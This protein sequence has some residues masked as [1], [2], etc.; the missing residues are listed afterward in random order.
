M[1]RVPSEGLS[2]R[3]RVARNLPHHPV[4][5]RALT[6]GTPSAGGRAPGGDLRSERTPIM[7]TLAEQVQGERMA[8]VALSMIAEP[9]D[10]ASGHALS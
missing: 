7:A 4:Y 2:R 5:D 6:E 3:T 10:A 8:R 9:N 1:N